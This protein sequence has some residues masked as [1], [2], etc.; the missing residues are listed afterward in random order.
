[1][2]A[3]PQSPSELTPA[4]LPGPDASSLRVEADKRYAD[5][6]ESVACDSCGAMSFE[7]VYPSA[8]TEHDLE[9]SLEQHT[10]SGW[11]NAAGR[12]VECR[13]CRLRFVSPRER[14][15][16]IWQTYR[17]I[18]DPLYLENLDS[19]R[20]SFARGLRQLERVRRAPGRLLDVGCSVG[21]FLSL[22]RESGWQVEGVEASEWSSEQARSLGLAVHNELFEQVTLP[23]ST[24][25]VVCFW[26]VLEHVPSPQAALV[27]AH[28]LLKPGGVL[29]VSTPNIWSLSARLLGRR[30]WFIERDHIFYYSPETLAEQLRRC[31][32]EPGKRHSVL[33]TYPARYLMRKLSSYLP[34]VAG[35][36][37]RVL[38]RLGLGGLQASI[39][40]GQMTVFAFKAESRPG[41]VSGLA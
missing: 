19:R 23:E 26:D 25:D 30:W 18:V 7:T 4:P 20:H 12:I 29:V 33:R 27:K 38:E 21:V 3:T 35:L 10:Y 32:F 17:H 16:G 11:T 8:L 9:H 2:A 13:A 37:E 1:M 28:R 36:A 39:P 40:S 5:R 31:G 24:Y 22:C 14:A 15:S 6:F 41:G 34:G